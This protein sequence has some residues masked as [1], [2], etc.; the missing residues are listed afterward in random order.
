MN[1]D[2]KLIFKRSIL[3]SLL[4]LI[5]STAL[6]F[7]LIQGL[8]VGMDLNP[9]RDWTVE[10]VVDQINF[11]SL[12]ISWTLVSILSFV[13]DLFQTR[14]NIYIHMTYLKVVI[15]SIFCSLLTIPLIGFGGF[16][17]YTIGVKSFIVSW[18]VM[19]CFEVLIA[20]IKYKKMNS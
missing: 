16:F 19:A 2:M 18:F 12:F 20:Y 10:E 4:Y 11:S 6:I 5:L 13:T 17:S 1:A 15:L 7:G 14:K 3:F 9:D 8:I